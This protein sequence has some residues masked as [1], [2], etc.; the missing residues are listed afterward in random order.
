M[1]AV[2]LCVPPRNGELCL[3]IRFELEADSTVLELTSRHRVT[4][5]ELDPETN[6]IALWIEITDPETSRPVDVRID[7]QA[8]GADVGTRALLL[9][10]IERNGEKRAV[11]GTY[12]GVVSDEN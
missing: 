1:R 5:V 3:P 4:S 6:R 10:E 7:V 9:D 2:T 11:Y 12:L 8:P